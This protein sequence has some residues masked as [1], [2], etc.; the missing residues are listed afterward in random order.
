MEKDIIF[1]DDDPFAPENHIYRVK[2]ILFSGRSEYQDVKVVEFEW[3]GLALVL[4]NVVQ[5]TEAE[6]FIYHETLAHIPLFTHPNPKNVLIIGGGDCGVAREVLK[7]KSVE[8]L[9]LVDLDKMVTEVSK[10][11]FYDLFKGAFEDK[12]L[13]IINEDGLKFVKEYDGD[14]FDVVMIDLTDPVG[15]AKP[16]FEEPFY[17]MVH[18]ILTD[19]GIMAAQTE[20]IWYHQETVIGVQKALK[21]VFPIV[22]V[23]YF[24]T[25]IY[26]GYWWT[27]SIGSKKYNPRT[28]YRSSFLNNKY[29]S[30]DVRNVSFLP[31]S[32][33][34]RL[35]EGR[36]FKESL[37]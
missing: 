2:N 9:I 21:N 37:R 20:S 29:Y 35:L 10:K 31:Q 19:D 7:H 23:A 12:R 6:E 25:P 3:F 34:D 14:K 13:R 33:Y 28:D 26:T 24:I 16:L 27:I 18:N 15:P 17:R 1:L 8:K 5:F 30:D 32:L 36:L 11:Y 4:D 22:D